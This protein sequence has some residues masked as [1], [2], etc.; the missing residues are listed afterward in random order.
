MLRGEEMRECENAGMHELEEGE[1]SD[2]VIGEE[3]KFVLLRKR[4]ESPY[5]RRRKNLCYFQV[6]KFDK[7]GYTKFPRLFLEGEPV[8]SI[9]RPDE[10]LQ[11]IFFSAKLTDKSGGG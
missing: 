10:V 6:L 4:A 8:P 7:Y 11:Q 2:W 1:M 9:E 5:V 3:M